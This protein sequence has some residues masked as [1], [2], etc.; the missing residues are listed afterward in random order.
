MAESYLRKRGIT[1]PLPMTLRFHPN[2]WHHA[3]RQRLPA[4]LALVERSDSF[5]IHRTPQK[6][7]L[8]LLLGVL[9]GFPK[10]HLRW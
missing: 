5:A 9:C 4:M 3:T 8:A 10:G 6:R 7:C 1:C 2:C